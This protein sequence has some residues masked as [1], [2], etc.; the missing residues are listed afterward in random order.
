M[1]LENQILLFFL[2]FDQELIM[3]LLL[4]LGRPSSRKV[5]DSNIANW[6]KMK[7]GRTVS[8]SSKYTPSS[9]VGFLICHQ[10]P[11]KMVAMTSCHK[12]PKAPSFQTSGHYDIS[13]RKVLLSGK[14]TCSIHVA[15]AAACTAITSVVS[16][17]SNSVYSS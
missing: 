13:Q 9:E 14:C 1:E 7:S 6:I 4:L 12:K 5:Y 17:T 11:F 8:S 15:P 3:L 2:F 16:T 10:M